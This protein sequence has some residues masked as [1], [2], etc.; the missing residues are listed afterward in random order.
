MSIAQ[1][2]I[3]HKGQTGKQFLRQEGKKDPVLSFTQLFQQP[4]VLEEI[5]V[6]EG[7]AET[8]TRSCADRKEPIGLKT[9]RY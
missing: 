1:A 5:G 7:H 3:L 6:R 8:N 4:L 2:A 9:F